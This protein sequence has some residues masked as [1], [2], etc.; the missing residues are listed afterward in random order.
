MLSNIIYNNLNQCLSYD[1]DKSF[2]TST[3]DLTTTIF[4]HLMGTVV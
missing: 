2:L 1:Y 3:I 4:K